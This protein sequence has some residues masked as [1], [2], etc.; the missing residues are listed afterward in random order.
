MK[1]LVILVCT[2]FFFGGCIESRTSNSES[3]Q[4][5]DLGLMIPDS[6]LANDGA[7]AASDTGTEPDVS[8]SET[9]TAADECGPG[10]DCV[11]GMCTEPECRADDQCTAFVQGCVEGACRDR[12]VGPGTCFRGGTCMGGFCVPPECEGD[13]DCTDGR[14]C[15]DGSCTEVA[16]C[17]ARDDCG[18]DEQCLD[19]LCE[20][21]PECI[22][23][24]Q[25]EGDSIC[26]TGRC[27]PQTNCEE[28]ILDCAD[29]EYCV[30]GRCVPN[31]CRGLSQCS[32]GE[33]CLGGE[34]V[35][36]P[37]RTVETVI[38]TQYPRLLRVGQE[39]VFTAVALD[40]RGDIIPG[41]GMITWASSDGRI[42]LGGFA[43]PAVGVVELWAIHTDS[44][45]QE[46]LS[47][48][49]RIEVIEA[50]PVVVDGVA[51]RVID[52]EDGRAI[53]GVL[54]RYD[55]QE[56]TTDETGIVQFTLVEGVT[57]LNAFSNEHDY[58]TVVGTFDGEYV[59]PLHRRSSND[60]IA[61]MSGTV[62]FSQIMS[63]GGV[64][65]SLS[66]PSVGSRLAD[67]S[68]GSIL[69][70]TFSVAISAGPA[71]FDM[72]IP[73]GVTLAA[74][75]PIVGRIEAKSEFYGTSEPGLRLAWSLAGRMDVGRLTQLAQGGGGAGIGRVLGVILP[76]FET[77]SHG[78]RVGDRLVALPRV[79]DENDMD[80][81]GDSEELR[82]DYER[83]PVLNLRPS[84]EQTLRLSIDAS[85]ITQPDELTIIFPGMDMP[86][87]GFVPLGVTAAEEPGVYPA[88]M[89]PA[90]DGLEEGN[91]LVM[92]ITARFGDGQ[93]LP[94]TLTL[95][96][97][98]S[99]RNVPLNT[100]FRVNDNQE[101]PIVRPEIAE[102]NSV[103]R[104][105]EGNGSQGADAHRLVLFGP[106]GRWDV[107]FDQGVET[108]IN[109]PFPPD[110]FDD[111]AAGPEQ[112]F[113][114]LQF[115][116]DAQRFM[117]I[118]RLSERENSSLSD[119]DRLLRTVGR[120]GL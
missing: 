92:A 100:S 108:A 50:N 93:V 25:C 91:P 22:G 99:A 49:V 2:L 5:Q 66:G 69:G 87:I 7:I 72:P 38:I 73:S 104:R 26:Q 94:D 52:A 96:F 95:H 107:Y 53:G 79:P 54:V 48:R 71:S 101:A 15:R 75:L 3:E 28:S 57:R 103:M 32:P 105:F 18:A 19:G 14:L 102:W 27:R 118:L 1:S 40:I 29:T 74:E 31:V 110:G 111:L 12:C 63:E 114:A 119:L 76:Y 34:C 43:G 83:F 84:R 60:R 9:C 98:R 62:D 17:M 97:Q 39:G 4:A 86:G 77:F 41:V 37:M 106:D 115:T 13:S 90:Y 45:G 81:D 21:L 116:Q 42:L 51:V 24:R 82:P 35:D 120:L 6:A 23:D 58:L 64:E 67:I 59:L 85:A 80:G 70:P 65:L 10:A 16:A 30:G 47:E 36:P 109:L 56:A 20:A 89:T 88:R 8:A 112:R 113:E 55:A 33:I 44:E 117:S 46:T 78:L 68:I 61:G 11:N